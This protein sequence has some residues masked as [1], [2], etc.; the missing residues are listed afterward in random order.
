M[1]LLIVDYTAVLLL[2]LS[3]LLLLNIILR[4]EL[5]PLSLLSAACLLQVFIIFFN[6]LSPDDFFF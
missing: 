6:C 4:A 3:V 5:L 2:L 1:G